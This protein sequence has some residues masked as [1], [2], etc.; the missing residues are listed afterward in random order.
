MKVCLSVLCVDSDSD[1]CAVS[2]TKIK[3]AV[4]KE[5]RPEKSS[6]DFG[7]QEWP[8]LMLFKV[9]RPVI[10]LSCYLIGWNFQMLLGYLPFESFLLGLA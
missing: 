10:D 3:A 5:V 9:R 4:V 7:P 1:C 2:S 6:T 8:E